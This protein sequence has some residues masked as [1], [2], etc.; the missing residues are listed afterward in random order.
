MSA[1]SIHPIIRQIIDRDCHV[2]ESYQSV[3]RHVVSKLKNGYES[4]RQLSKVDRKS[5]I[6]QCIA[7]H[8]ANRRL[9]AEVMNGFPAT[10]RIEADLLHH[11]ENVAGAELVSMMREHNKTEAFMAF[12]L[13]WSTRRIQSA[14]NSGLTNPGS[15]KDWLQALAE[16]D[17]NETPAKYRVCNT[18][19]SSDCK[20][21]GC[22]LIGGDMVFSYRQNVYCSNYCC[23]KSR[24]W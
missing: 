10:R 5:L 3:I 15:I 24:G 13:G 2:G 21:C 18:Q 4:F 19:A 20:F 7:Q 1:K 22:P 17:T 14:C 23:R 11:I 16:D 9:Y 8:T 6:E 12:R